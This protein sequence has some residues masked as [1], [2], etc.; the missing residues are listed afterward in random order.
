MI[1][2]VSPRHDK[3]FIFHLLITFALLLNLEESSDKLPSSLIADNATLA[4]NSA[5]YCCLFC[6]TRQLCEPCQWRG[7]P[8][9]IKQKIFFILLPQPSFFIIKSRELKWDFYKARI[10]GPEAYETLRYP[11]PLGLEPGKILESSQ[12]K[13]IQGLQTVLANIN[14]KVKI[15]YFWARI[16]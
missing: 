7:N 9:T 5:L 14:Y 1:S 10:G 11:W 3:A 13:S 8:I 2:I 12:W 16:E 6:I 15:W 4:L